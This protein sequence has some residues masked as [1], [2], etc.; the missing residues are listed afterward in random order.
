MPIEI[1][2]NGNTHS[3]SSRQTILGLIRELGLDPARVAVELD[4]AIV[5]QARWA[6]TPLHNGAALEVVQ[7]VGGG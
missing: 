6:D 5:K 4:R 3:T 2:V 7:F 1:F